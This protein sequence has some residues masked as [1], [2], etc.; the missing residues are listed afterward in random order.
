MLLYALLLLAAC[1]NTEDKLESAFLD[2]AL[3]SIDVTPSSSTINVGGKTQYTATGVYSDTTNANLTDNAT[4]KS[5]NTSVV[6]IN[7]LGLATGVAS[8][9]PVEI[10][11]TYSGKIGKAYITVN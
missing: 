2:A 11:A 10:S 1:G 8:G 5:S 6:T 9:G 7:S 3:Y 4:W